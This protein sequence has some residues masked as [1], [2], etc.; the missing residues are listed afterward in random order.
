MEAAKDSRVV[1]LQQKPGLPA[2]SPVEGENE[3]AAAA[4]TELALTE[5]VASPYQ[6]RQFDDSETL[7]ELVQSIHSHGVLQPVLVRRKPDGERSCYEL[8][9]GERRF[10]A[11]QLAG[12]PKIPAIISDLS[13]RDAVE[14]SIIE[15]AQRENLNAIEEAKALL[16][17]SKTFSLAQN[18]IAQSIGKSRAAVANSLRLLQLDREV[19]ELITS[20]QLSGGHGKALLAIEN[21][22]LQRR[23]ARRAARSALSVRVLEELVQRVKER[24][25][26]K[27]PKK[28][29]PPPDTRELAK[30]QS[31]LGVEKVSLRPVENGGRS[32]TICFDDEKSWKK[33]LT[34]LRR[35]S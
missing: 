24:L 18:E 32:V 20:G 21:R 11:A 35:R 34:Q 19:Q 8:V 33:F 22:L 9:A 28:K 16:I 10:R 27:K 3:S 5:I 23:L 31:L 13:D 7:S 6:T 26:A 25:D 30:L 14:I 15:N 4:V 2:A 29:L 12:L 1:F 17:L